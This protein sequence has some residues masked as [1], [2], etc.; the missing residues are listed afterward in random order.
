M[1]ASVTD[2]G[3]RVLRKLG[4]AMV[5]ASSRA[6]GVGTV[7]QTDIGLRALRAV[8]VNPAA[9]ASVGS[10]LVRSLTDVATGALLKLAVIASD[11]TPSVTD[12]AEA[13]GRTQ[14]VHDMLASLQ[15]VGWSSNAI[16]DA[17]AEWYVIMTAQLVAPAFGKPANMDV[18]NA[19]MAALRQLALGGPYGQAIAEQKAAETH[20][21]LNAAAIVSWPISAIPV[22]QAEDYV[23]MTAALLAPVYGMDPQA[24][25]AA[26]A[27]ANAAMVNIRKQA[28]I[29]GSQAVAE[30]KVIAAYV[31]LDARG[32]TRFSLLDLPDWA[33]EPLVLM[34]C[35]LAAPEF[36]V[37]VDPAWSAQAEMDLMRIVSFPGDREPVRA[38][39]F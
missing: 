39:Y 30:Q 6:A 10:G 38:V 22:A 11:E 13:V 1:T 14:A 19:A 12:L 24:V 18:F 17:A 23:T 29:A 36:E 20:E 28:M 5:A 35:V 32:R 8:G 15:V 27:A 31:S 34:A 7:N 9:A 3:A 37:K 2:L 25:Q 26:N 16:P 33:E 21:R 4:V